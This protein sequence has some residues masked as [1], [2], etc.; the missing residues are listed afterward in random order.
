MNVFF[1][2]FNFT[3]YVQQPHPILV[4]TANSTIVNVLNNIVPDV[5]VYFDDTKIFAKVVASGNDKFHLNHNFIGLKIDPYAPGQTMAQA[6]GMHQVGDTIY[7]TSSASNTNYSLATL[8]G[9]VEHIN[10]IDG[11]IH[12]TP[13]NGAPILTS[14]SNLVIHNLNSD[15]RVGG[16]VYYANA[17]SVISSRVS[18]T[19]NLTF[20]NTH[21]SIE[22]KLLSTFQTIR[23][24]DIRGFYDYDQ[25]G[26]DS[27]TSNTQNL[28]HGTGWFANT[29]NSNII[30]T[31]FWFDN[32]IHAS[33][34]VGNR[35]TITT[36]QNAGEYANIVSIVTNDTYWNYHDFGW[37]NALGTIVLDKY[38]AS[39]PRR[40]FRFSVS[41]NS[42]GISK[43]DPDGNHHI[44]VNLPDGDNVTLSTGKH[45]IHVT[46][47]ST[48]NS[49]NAKIIGVGHH[50]STGGLGGGHRK[51]KTPD[52]DWG[53][54]DAPPGPK[55]TS[56]DP[57]DL[58]NNPTL[59]YPVS[60]SDSNSAP[61]VINI[62]QNL[63]Q[64]FTTPKPTSLKQNYG[65]FIT[66]V[67]L[68]F[69]S[70]PDIANTG[71]PAQPVI[72]CISPTAGGFPTSSALASTAV[73]YRD[74][75]VSQYP[76]VGNTSSE[77]VFTF[78]DPVYL[79]AD[80]EYAIVVKCKSSDYTLYTAVLGE[81][82][83]VNP[84]LSS[85]G[86][87]NTSISRKVSQQPSVGN[88]YTAQNSSLWTPI[89]NEDL[90]FVIK[91]AQFV[92]GNQEA[93]FNMKA[94]H[95]TFY[96]DR[97]LFTSFDLTFPSGN[98]QYIA[99]TL[100]ASSNTFTGD[101]TGTVQ[102]IPNQVY[103][104]GYDLSIS[105][106]ESN[107]R[108][109]LLSGNTDSINVAVTMST[110][111]PDISPVFNYEAING[112]AYQNIINYGELDPGIL[113]ISTAGHTS[114][115]SNLTFTISI[116][117][118]PDGIQAT[119]N[120][121]NCVYDSGNT[122]PGAVG[123]LTFVFFDSVGSGYTNNATITVTSKDNTDVVPVV[124]VNGETGSHGGNMFCKY[125]TKKIT[126]ADGFDSGDMRV[127]VTTIKPAG[128]QVLA[129]YKVRSSAD[130]DSIALKPWVQMQVVTPR[131]SP[132]QQTPVD[133][134]FSPGAP[135]NANANAVIQS[136][137]TLN[138]LHYVENGIT[139]PIGGSFKEFAIKLVLMAKDP[140][141]YPVVLNMRAV[142]VPAG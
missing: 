132:D 48:S 128:T 65:I 88:L 14:T 57:A 139:Y 36:G 24:S 123:N 134:T 122:G 8:T 119:I 28:L 13:L 60:G 9:L 133:L 7:L 69:N 42:V 94:V 86:T 141:V 77:T 108:R 68:Y 4:N 23:G 41:N 15:R 30:T 93:F 96:Y 47:G 39:N 79:D 82:A 40:L 11:I 140:T 136:T 22:P 32:F 33:L 70:K 129:Y 61:T 91:K 118:L 52:L 142:T 78:D 31:A 109:A 59:V 67:V 105:N 89:P 51:K 19:G 43:T 58:I 17:N 137:Q 63:S 126:L 98:L 37:G 71:I 114:N 5:G 35:V 44:I 95:E 80:T 87:S 99:N 10:A 75:K 21:E 113:S 121:S 101:T 106:Y 62:K 1:E 131:T 12:I 20:V 18:N 26:A 76:E 53:G 125:V 29:A 85:S 73:E 90:M 81:S 84:A 83:L 92:T 54:H 45:K 112:I 55:R 56:D 72:V 27:A 110:D 138:Q 104:F 124:Q 34:H 130:S 111:D 100:L 2:N 102:L 3:P 115:S 49:S 25:F 74:I 38:L 64:T 116:P 50:N 127:Y 103:S 16:Q 107:R 97:I 117:D 135:L 46:D 120:A 6:V 66:S